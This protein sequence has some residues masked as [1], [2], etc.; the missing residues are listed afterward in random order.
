VLGLDQLSKDPKVVGTNF[1]LAIILLIVL[2]FTSAVFNGTLD[3]HR[4]EVQSFMRRL[5]APFR[6][7]GALQR[8]Q[9]GPFAQAAWAERIIGPVLLLGITCLI[10]TLNE[11]GFGWNGKT[12]A[13]F[14]SLVI[15]VGVTT[16]VVE[17]G[18]V[19]ITTRRFRVPAAVRL[20]PVAIAIAGGFVLLSRVTSFEAPIMYGFVGSAAALTAVKLEQRE[21]A[22]AVLLPALVLLALSLA[23]WFLLV[24][25]RHAT[26]DD[27]NWWAHVPSDTAALIFAAGIEGLLFTMIPVRFTDGAKIF[28]WHRLLWFPLFLIPAFL[29]SWV[30]LNPAAKGFDA[31]IEG[32][33]I[34]AL[35]LVGAYV[36]STVAFWAF[37]ALRDRGEAPAPPPAPPSGTGGGR[38]A[39]AH[40]PALA[41]LEGDLSAALPHDM[42]VYLTLYRRPRE[43]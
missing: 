14:T 23:A 4:V 25:L 9:L 7:L 22:F 41:P 43:T 32:R 5:T 8:E 12:A 3:E 15:G 13:L 31:L 20:F 6:W 33:V 42:P 40:R 37:F 29:F 39:H 11:S 30:L 10:Y 36:A 38:D 35:A 1:L 27:G 28:R 2:L 18:E 16:Y 24:P 34:F 19:L 21:S 17:G 26:W